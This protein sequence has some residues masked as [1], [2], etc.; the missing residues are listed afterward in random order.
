[1]E[2][3][4]FPFNQGSG[5][6]WN[7]LKPEQQDFLVQAG[8]EKEKQKEAFRTDHAQ[9]RDQRVADTEEALLKH[10][11]AQI[12]APRPKGFPPPRMKTGPEI[13]SEAESK[14]DKAYTD[15]LQKLETDH[16]KA[17]RDYIKQALGIEPRGPERPDHGIDRT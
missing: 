16:R 7:R 11:K 8:V 5:A 14:V 12:Q 3:N 9:N 15:R 10:Y 1:M 13:R 17:E 6:N 4:N 2:K